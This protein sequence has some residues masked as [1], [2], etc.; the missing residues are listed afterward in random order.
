MVELTIGILMTVIALYVPG[1]LF[2][3][4][5]RFSRIASVVAAPLFS[6]TVYGVLPI[7]YYE[8]GI[9]CTVPTTFG[10][11]L[12][13]GIAAFA[14]RRVS[15]KE[16][17]PTIALPQP[18][19]IWLPRN[20][21]HTRDW[22]LLAL[23]ILVGIIAC[24]VYFGSNLPVPDAM[25]IRYDNQTHLTIAKS[26]LDSGMWSSLHPSYFLDLPLDQR[27]IAPSSSFYPSLLSALTALCA[28]MSGLGAT[29][30]FN[31]V[32]FA[33]CA[34]V[35]PAGMFAIMRVAF[36]GNT[37]IIAAGALAAVCFT[38]FPW[39][40]FV[41]ALFP[42]VG[43][44]A[45][46]LPAIGA[47]MIAFTDATLKRAA[48]R[49]AGI[50]VVAMPG[51]ALMQPNAVFAAF[52]FLG[53]Y[54]AHWCGCLAAQP[55]VSDEGDKPAR[56]DRS[57]RW[58]AIGIVTVCCCIVWAICLNLPPLQSVVR[59]F[60]N[61]IMDPLN[62][63]KKTVFFSFAPFKHE[64]LLGL[65]VIV[66][67]VACIKK[68]ILW[69][70]FPAAFMAAAY[71]TVRT[72]NNALTHILGGF[73][74]TDHVRIAAAYSLFLAPITAVG[75]VSIAKGAA[76]IVGRVFSCNTS[77]WQAAAASCA[78]VLFCIINFFPNF[79]VPGGSTERQTG[80]GSVYS[81]MHDMY[82]LSDSHVYSGDEYAFVT[83]AREIVGE[84]LVIN[85]PGDGSIFAYSGNDLCIY[86]RTT[87]FKG[88]SDAARTI[89]KH[90][91]KYGKNENVQ[92]AVRSTG[93]TY[94]LKLDHGVSYED[95]TWF[96]QFS[97]PERWTGIE[98]VG[99][100]TAGFTVVLS[101]G[102]MRLYRIDAV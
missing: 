81:V 90:L 22:A 33:L 54:L 100:D 30:A 64:Y 101:E 47:T 26:F 71:F 58:I 52:V 24:V 94:V 59:Y 5:M 12:A 55:K 48:L 102:D 66:G 18:S 31:A 50:W 51:L 39:G 49:V 69:P 32:L 78:V 41:R 14:A 27:S 56:S 3:R 96:N 16:L 1:Y 84:D 93:A 91:Y 60:G 23:Y 62:I 44:F 92:A 87:K 9:P 38:G 70:L 20:T 80:M 46:M 63:L 77:Q 7:P 8:L 65:V 72:Q 85:Y 88:E 82:A 17:A 15:G 28:L 21:E 25:H 2:F 11:A 36:P 40:L 4:A 67:I 83:K 74:Y 37:G 53:A 13:I 42:N 98:K 79:T 97:R 68:R 34:I 29:A 95:G 6:C 10:V 86:Y 75:I 45:L 43:A 76:S 61:T 73:W 35:A 57:R 99:D 19:G 89:R